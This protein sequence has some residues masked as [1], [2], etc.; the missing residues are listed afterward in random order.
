MGRWAMAL[1]VRKNIST[2]LNYSSPL[3]YRIVC[4][5]PALL[6]M[7]S[8]RLPTRPPHCKANDEAEDETSCCQPAHRAV[9]SAQ[10]PKIHSSTDSKRQEAIC[11]CMPFRSGSTDQA[12][13]VY[14]IV[15]QL[16]THFIYLL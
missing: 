2:L 3:F 8:C 15:S 10:W 1:L 9:A 7:I 5:A 6:I 12:K 11:C 14:F 13:L 4:P 16:Y